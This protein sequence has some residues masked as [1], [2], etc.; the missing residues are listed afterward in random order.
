MQYVYHLRLINLT[1]RNLVAFTAGC[2][3]M[4]LMCYCYILLTADDQIYVDHKRNLQN[5]TCVL[6]LQC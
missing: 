6:R 2:L 4:C 1:S 5:I 3:N